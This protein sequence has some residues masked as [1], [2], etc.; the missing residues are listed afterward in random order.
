MTERRNPPGNVHTSV[1]LTVN[2]QTVTGVGKD[3]AG[4]HLAAK[5]PNAA[6]AVN[7][8]EIAAD[9]AVARLTAK[10][11]NGAMAGNVAEIAARAEIPER[12]LGNAKRHRPNLPLSKTNRR[13]SPTRLSILLKSCLTEAL[14]LRNPKTRTAR[15]DLQAKAV[16]GLETAAGTVEV[17]VVALETAGAIAH[18]AKAASVP[19]SAPAVAVAA[20]VAAVAVEEEETVPTNL[21]LRPRPTQV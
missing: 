16:R 11:P 17:A 3:H 6:K 7:V 21:L 4:A 13:R 15:K 14:P 9:H 10:A 1:L 12:D 20:A 5:A 8:V 18:G 19:A 2:V